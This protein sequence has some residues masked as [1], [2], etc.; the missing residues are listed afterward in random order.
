MGLRPL[1][2]LDFRDYEFEILL[3]ISQMQIPRSPSPRKRGYGRLGMTRRV[4]FHPFR[5]AREI[6][7][8]TPDHFW[9]AKWA[10]TNSSNTPPVLEGCTNT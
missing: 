5:K 10:S 6:G 9:L 2:Y 4:E 7:W 3:Q 8:G 1:K